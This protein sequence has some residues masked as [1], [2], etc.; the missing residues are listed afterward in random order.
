MS[1]TFSFLTHCVYSL[2]LR[3]KIVLP[4]SKEITQGL[5]TGEW[6]LIKIFTKYKKS[7][8]IDVNS[9]FTKDYRD[10]NKPK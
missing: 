5:N 8:N 9:V 7:I 1:V 4:I 6:I 10:Q 2:S 3:K